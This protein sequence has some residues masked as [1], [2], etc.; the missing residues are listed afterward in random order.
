VIV[1][2]SDG[3]PVLFP[4]EGGEP[5]TVP[6]LTAEDSVV[7]FNAGGQSLLVARGDLPLVISRVDIAS[8]RRERIGEI[9]PS[10]RTGI[11]GIFNVS[12]T[13]DAKTYAYTIQRRLSTLYLVT[14]LK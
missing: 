5:R 1:G 9:N 8:G 14:G 10:D 11:D 3:K 7:R 2:G 13:P 6:G 4:I 12:L